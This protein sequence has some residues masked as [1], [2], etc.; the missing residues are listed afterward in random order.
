[1][2]SF[3]PTRPP[4]VRAGVVPDPALLCEFPRCMALLP[5][6][7]SVVPTGLQLPELRAARRA[8]R[9][10]LVV[11][12]TRMLPYV[13][14]CSPHRQAGGGNGGGGGDGV[15]R[16]MVARRGARAKSNERANCTTAARRRDRASACVAGN[17]AFLRSCRASCL[18]PLPPHTGTRALAPSRPLCPSATTTCASSARRRIS[19]LASG[20]SPSA[21]CQQRSDCSIQRPLG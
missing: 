7:A 6:L 11:S 14:M 4:D 8:V 19:M 3:T 18:L 13:H 2:S 21:Q 9:V 16:T 12:G 10:R 1:M 15:R 5:P 20:L 17:C